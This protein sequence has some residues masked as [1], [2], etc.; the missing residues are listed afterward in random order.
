MAGGDADA[1][2]QQDGRVVALSRH[3]PEPLTAEAQIGQH[4]GDAAHP[5]SADTDEVNVLN[6]MFSFRSHFTDFSAHSSQTPCHF[7]RCIRFGHGAC[8]F[9][10]LQH[11][12]VRV[13]ADQAD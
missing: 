5:G 9:G 7:G 1:P 4:L 2:D 11:L 3:G 6:L 12:A 13:I 10:H 8:A